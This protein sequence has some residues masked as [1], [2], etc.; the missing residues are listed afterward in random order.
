MILNIEIQQ[1]KTRVKLYY[2]QLHLKYLCNLARYWQRAPW[3]WHNSVE[4][5]RSSKIRSSIINCHL[6]CAFACSL[7]KIKKIQITFCPDS[8]SALSCAKHTFSTPKTSFS[9]WR[10]GVFLIGKCQHMG[11]RGSLALYPSSRAQARKLFK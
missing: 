3:R 1:Q 5:C 8:K 10:N 2:Q 4:T 11:G 9:R 6:I 7:Y